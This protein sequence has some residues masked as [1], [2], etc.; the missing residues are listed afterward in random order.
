MK[1]KGVIAGS[2]EAGNTAGAGY[3]NPIEVLHVA[4][5]FTLPISLVYTH[6]Q[7]NKHDAVDRDQSK[8][9]CIPDCEQAGRPLGPIDGR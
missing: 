2:I 5:F 1:G 8:V 3:V 9:S 7:M 4:L 6:R